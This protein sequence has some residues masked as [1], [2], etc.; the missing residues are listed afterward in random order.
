MILY[1]KL[2][3]KEYKTIDSD[4]LNINQYLTILDILEDKENDL[5]E[6]SKDL[7]KEIT[8]IPFDYIDKIDSFNLVLIDWVSFI[9][10]LQNLNKIKQSYYGYT[11]K[12]L[13][14][15]TFGNYIDLDY[16]LINKDLIGVISLMLLPNDYTMSDLTNIK[17]LT[18][19]MPTK[20]AISILNYFISYRKN[21]F[22]SFESL[23]DS[24][25]EDDDDE[26]YTEEELKKIKKQEDKIKTYSSWLETAYFL[27]N[28]D[29]TKNDIIL[30]KPFI[31]TL[32]YLTWYK[33]E[34]D[35]EVQQLKKY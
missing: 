23:F 24:P 19:K 13:D 26:G 8:D 30:K 31:E 17:E 29:I 7:L 22:N 14:E 33:A 16:F 27:S 5:L 9:R 15:L 18:S 20:D 2:N 6:L 34:L 32:N 28:R 11:L 1:F 10:D 4:L 3:K 21:I 12:N 35:R 25:E